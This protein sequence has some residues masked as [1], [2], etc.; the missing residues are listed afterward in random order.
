MTH[1]AGLLAQPDRV[2]RPSLAPRARRLGRRPVRPVSL[3]PLAP[4]RHGGPAK[5][6]LAPFSAGLVPEYRLSLGGA[7]RR[8]G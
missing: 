1:T 8:A 3:E 5:P 2:R 4:F 7:A 6:D